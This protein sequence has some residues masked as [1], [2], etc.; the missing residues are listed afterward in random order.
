MNETWRITYLITVLY[1]ATHC[2]STKGAVFLR[3]NLYEP[4]EGLT[5]LRQFVRLHCPM[6]R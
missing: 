6:A 1:F 3:K 4:F 5:R 2:R